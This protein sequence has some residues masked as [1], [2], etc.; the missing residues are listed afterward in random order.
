MLNPSFPEGN[1]SHDRP[2]WTTERQSDLTIPHRRQPGELLNANGQTLC[3][4]TETNPAED[5]ST[6]Q[7]QTRFEGKSLTLNRPIDGRTYHPEVASG[8]NISGS[9]R[10]AE[11]MSDIISRPPMVESASSPV[12]SIPS[13][14]DSA[15]SPTYVRNSPALQAKLSF[16]HRISPIDASRV[17][18]HPYSKSLGPIQGR[19][20]VSAS[21]MP[22]YKPNSPELYSNGI[23]SASTSGLRDS[24]RR[25]PRPEFPTSPRSISRRNEEEY[26]TGS[27]YDYAHT[28][29]VLRVPMTPFAH[30]IGMASPILPIMPGSAGPVMS[31]RGSGGLPVSSMRERSHPTNISRSNSRNEERPGAAPR[32]QPKADAIPRSYVLKSLNNLAAHFWNR[33]ATADC[34]IS[35]LHRIFLCLNNGN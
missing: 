23:T 31:R 24:P 35:K 11:K 12:V 5:I 28:P 4:K 29:S 32:G 9:T 30:E 7:K 33:S 1:A 19:G 17:S 21:N 6:L 2:T 18:N 34:R 27:P 8:S 22:T 25:R 3:F 26:R 15:I 14:A 20:P 10:R 13:W 16:Q